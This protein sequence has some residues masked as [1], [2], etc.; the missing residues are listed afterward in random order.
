MKGI[1][2]IER[3]PRP[4]QKKTIHS[5]LRYR[6]RHEKFCV[7]FSLVHP[8]ARDL[9]CGFD[10]RFSAL[11][12]VLSR[13][14]PFLNATSSVRGSMVSYRCLKLIDFAT[15][16]IHDSSS[17]NV[18]GIPFLQTA[19]SK[20]AHTFSVMFMSGDL[21][22]SRTIDKPLLRAQ[23]SVCLEMWTVASSRY[24]VR[25]LPRLST[26]DS[27]FKM[28]SIKLH[29]KLNIKLQLSPHLRRD[30]CVGAVVS[31]TSCNALQPS[32]NDL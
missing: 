15:S 17:V 1:L 22:A 18:F 24:K 27:G 25:P 13:S 12:Q 21:G 31:D 28:M 7:D 6:G 9:R 29:I 32:F 20:A 19:F 14:F 16:L 3:S 26:A 30:F 8:Y 4:T 5:V 2:R 10:R 23:L 11:R